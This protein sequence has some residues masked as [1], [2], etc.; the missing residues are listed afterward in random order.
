VDAAVTGPAATAVCAIACGVLVIAEWRGPAAPRALAKLVASAAFLVVA[1]SVDAGRPFGSW[2]LAGLALG[3]VGDACLLGRGRRMFLG[4]LIAFL[5]GHL[6][7]VAGLAQLVPAGGWL[8]AAGAY[9]ALPICAGGAVLAWLW[10]R[11]PPLRVPVIV[12]VAAIAAMVV[13]AIAAFRAG[14]LPAPQ[15]IWLLAG[16]ALFFVSDLA[17]ARDRFVARGFANKLWG[18]P[19]YYA[20][21]LL[22][23]WSTSG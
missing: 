9:A 5:L 18:L 17:V 4:G 11:L 8:G 16:A 20:G 2:I 10:P 7:Y 14:A 23:A 3:A 6:A 12:Y 22:I 21:Q 13:G 15:R 1:A 19:A